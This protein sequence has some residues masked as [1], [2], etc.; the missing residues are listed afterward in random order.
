M[1]LRQNVFICNCRSFGSY[2]YYWDLLMF[3]H[4]PLGFLHRKIFISSGNT[5]CFV[6]NLILALAQWIAVNACTNM[7]FSDLNVL[8]T[9]ASW[10]TERQN[11]H[12]IF[13]EANWEM[14]RFLLVLLALQT[15]E[16]FRSQFIQLQW[17]C[18]IKLLYEMSVYGIHPLRTT[19]AV[20]LDFCHMSRG[21]W[22]G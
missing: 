14:N 20:S 19:G 7:E 8:W 18:H 9:E 4:K 22:R 12:L 6:I 13:S 11:W 17:I 1:W 16:N 21:H 2:M 5:F 10:D 3:F 15:L